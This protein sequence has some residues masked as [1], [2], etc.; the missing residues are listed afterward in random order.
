MQHCAGN[1][2]VCSQ[3]PRPGWLRRSLCRCVSSS[4]SPGRSLREGPAHSPVSLLRFC[5]LWLLPPPV[6]L[7]QSP[8]GRLCPAV[9]Y[10]L[11]KVLCSQKQSCPSTQG[12]WWALKPGDEGWATQRDLGRDAGVLLLFPLWRT[13]RSGQFPSPGPSS[14]SP[15]T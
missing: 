9:S 3:N 1:L 4:S 15:V 14:T 2:V 7:F 8:G 12:L 6:P 10:A 13:A 11:V 5:W